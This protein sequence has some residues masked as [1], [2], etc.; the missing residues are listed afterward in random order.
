MLGRWHDFLM[1]LGTAAATLVGLMF[2]AV[3]V[4][5]GM[6]SRERQ[7]PVR[8]LLSPTVV[9][10][11]CVLAVCLIGV[12]PVPDWTSLALLLGGV[13]GFGLI[14]SVAVFRR[15]ARE[16]LLAKTDLED[17]TW[18][19]TVPAVAYLILIAAATAFWRGEPAGCDL[20]VVGTGLLML[21]GLRNAWD[22]TTWVVMMRSKE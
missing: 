8:T 10:F 22:M 4:G 7:A 11:S 16:G 6:F 3:S 21:A 19:A 5:Q 2:V 14:Y 18:Y 12:A 20:L 17:R 9:A 1:L 13:G 15:M